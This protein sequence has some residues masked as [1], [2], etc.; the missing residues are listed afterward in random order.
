MAVIW[1]VVDHPTY[2]PEL[3]PSDLQFFGPF[4]K[5]LAKKWLKTDANVKQAVTSCLQKLDTEFFYAVTQT[6]LPGMDKWL[7]IGDNYVEVWCVP[8]ATHVSCKYRNLDKALGIRMVV[9]SLSS[10]LYS[11]N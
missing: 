8:S 11:V 4:I 10:F 1:E 6:L 9:T 2:S 3:A 7:N 5:Q